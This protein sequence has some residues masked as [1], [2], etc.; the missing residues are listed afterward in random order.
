MSD[1]A[2]REELR[3]VVLSAIMCMTGQA[4]TPTSRA[5]RTLLLIDEAW[6]MLKG[7]S[8]GA[9]V[10]PYARTA[11]KYG[12][13]LAPAPPS[14]N[15]YYTTDGE[16][17]ALQNLATLLYLP[18]PAETIYNFDHTRLLQQPHGRIGT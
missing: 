10:G 11:R 1:L 6:S 18:P 5:T 3:S 2:S 4:M 13:P 14:M 16:R 9:F 7:G 8:M 12:G 15:V 17:P